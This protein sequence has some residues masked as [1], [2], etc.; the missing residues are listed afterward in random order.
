MIK[1]CPE[2]HHEDYNK[3]Y[4]VDFVCK[5]CHQELDNLKRERDRK[6]LI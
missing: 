1:I 5:E 6:C 4:E 3:P 2:K